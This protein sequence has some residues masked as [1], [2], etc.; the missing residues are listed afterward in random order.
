MAVIVAQL[1]LLQLDPYEKRLQVVAYYAYPTYNQS[2]KFGDVAIVEV[3][4]KMTF[5]L[6]NKI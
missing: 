2:T 4:T 3:K 6:R 1:S 5:V